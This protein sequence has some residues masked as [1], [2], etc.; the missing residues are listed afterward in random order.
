M[1]V[2]CRRSALR[3][4]FLF[5]ALLSLSSRDGLGLTAATVETGSTSAKTGGRGRA[6][7][8]L[9]HSAVAPH[10]TDLTLPCAQADSGSRI[11]SSP[12]GDECSLWRDADTG[13]CWCS[14]WQQH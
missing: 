13:W 9:A 7:E 6:S 10:R 2:V 4:T 14:E 3:L 8:R 12:F 5:S 11:S 1:V